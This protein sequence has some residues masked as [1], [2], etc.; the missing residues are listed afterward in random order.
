M[1]NAEKIDYFMSLDYRMLVEKA[2]DE[3][4]YVVSFP[5][6]E[7]CLTSGWTMQEAIANAEDAKRSWFEACL[8]EGLEVPLPDQSRKFSGRFQVRVPALLHRRLYEHAA[9]QGVSMNQ[10]VT[11]LLTMNDS[12]LE[13]EAHSPL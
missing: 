9:S 4:G 1:T 13:K 11:M 2:V 10:Y 3:D 7:G 8:E 12:R 5:D 6:L